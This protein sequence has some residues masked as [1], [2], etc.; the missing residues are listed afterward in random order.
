VLVF[1]NKLSEEEAIQNNKG[2]LNKSKVGLFKKNC[3]IRNTLSVDFKEKLESFD[4]WLGYIENFRDAIAHRIPVYIPPFNISE[5]NTELNKQ[6]ERQKFLALKVK[7]LDFETFELRQ[8]ELREYW[9]VIRH[10]LIEE[11]RSVS[12]HFQMLRDF[13][14]VYEIACQLLNELPNKPRFQ[15][16]P[17]KSIL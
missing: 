4:N 12:V 13:M 9:P 3:F 8:S 17:L 14:T 2:E 6:L 7:S 1:E 11:P 5:E 16:F 10:S 15:T